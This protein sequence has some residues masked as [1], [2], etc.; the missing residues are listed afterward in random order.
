MEPEEATGVT[1]AKAT[2]LLASAKSV[3]APKTAS[4]VH[5]QST[6]IFGDYPKRPKPKKGETRAFR[7]PRPG[8]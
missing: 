7:I 1:D 6:L 5:P 3:C 4:H 8:R 2:D